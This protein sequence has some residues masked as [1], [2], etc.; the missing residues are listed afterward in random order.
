LGKRVLRQITHSLAE[1]PVIIKV[2][3][4]KTCLKTLLYNI[5]GAE[6]ENLASPTDFSSFGRA[7]DCSSFAF[8]DRGVAGSIPASRK[9]NMYF[10]KIPIKRSN[11]MISYANSY[12]Q[13]LNL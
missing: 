9:F 6:I 10:T 5:L 4:Y 12:Q 7:L 3:D 2:F 8:S 11:N 13:H 1:H